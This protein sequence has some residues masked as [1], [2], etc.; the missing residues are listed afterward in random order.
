MSVDLAGYR[1]LSSFVGIGTGAGK[2]LNVYNTSGTTITEISSIA[3]CNS[4]SSDKTFKMWQVTNLIWQNSG[5]WNSGANVEPST[6]IKDRLF[7]ESEIP[8]NQTWFLP[9]SIILDGN[10]YL[11]F[12]GTSDLSITIWGKEDT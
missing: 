11:I 3:I 8:A 7:Y 4:S 10:Q 2:Y 1:K 5:D 6:A 12:E 9:V